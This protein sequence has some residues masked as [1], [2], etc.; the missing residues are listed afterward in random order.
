[1]INVYFNH[2]IR[3]T[4][5]WQAVRTFFGVNVC[6]IHSYQYYLKGRI[7]QWGKAEAIYQV[8]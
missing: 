6:G 4:H 3:H 2:G 1:M 7:S 8:P 5:I